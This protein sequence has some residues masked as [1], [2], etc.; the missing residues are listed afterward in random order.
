[1]EQLRLRDRGL[2]L[3][4]PSSGFAWIARTTTILSVLVSLFSGISLVHVVSTRELLQY[5]DYEPPPPLSIKE[6]GAML[7]QELV[8]RYVAQWI[9]WMDMN[10]MAS[11]GC[12]CMHFVF[13]VYI[14]NFYLTPQT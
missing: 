8:S 4:K 3:S 11:H 1:M 5:Y 6:C 9:I 10:C 14:V 13:V 12:G 7:G 2:G